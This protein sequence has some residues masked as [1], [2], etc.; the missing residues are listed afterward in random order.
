MFTARAVAKR[1][2]GPF[3]SRLIF[4][5]FAEKFFVRRQRSREISRSKSRTLFGPLP[6]L[7]PD[8]R[9]GLNGSMQRHLIEIFSL[10]VVLDEAR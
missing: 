7:M 10:K 1:G 4:S 2:R 5:L 8:E 6:V 9:G 3:G